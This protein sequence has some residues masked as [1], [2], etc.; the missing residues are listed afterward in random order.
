MARA[1]FPMA[2]SRQILDHNDPDTIDHLLQ[3]LD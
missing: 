3:G 2:I 1:G